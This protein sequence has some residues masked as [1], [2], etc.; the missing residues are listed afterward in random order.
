MV[1]MQIMLAF[2]NRQFAENG[3][4]FSENFWAVLKRQIPHFLVDI[5]LELFSIPAN[6]EKEKLLIFFQA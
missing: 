3:I 5:R 6:I 4:I 2:L 1:N